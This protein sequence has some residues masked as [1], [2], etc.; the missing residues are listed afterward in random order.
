M[1]VYRLNLVIALALSCLAASPVPA[2]AGEIL[3]NTAG[4]DYNAPVTTLKE[5]RFRRV[6]KQSYDFSCG[7]AAVATLLT[8]HYNRPILEQTVLQAMFEV[9]DQEKIRKEGFSM[10][11]MKKYLESLGYRV[12]G[13]QVSLDKVG[14]VGIPGI[15]LIKTN[16]YLHFVVLK[17][18]RGGQ[19]LL[20]DSALGTKFMSREKFIEV[21]NGIFLAIITGTRQAKNEF[22]LDKDWEGQ[23]AA[24][25]GR[26]LSRE[27]L[28]TLTLLM[29]GRNNF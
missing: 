1:A 6:V 8:Y 10:L 15:V 26:A 27:S 16:G 23:V 28:S 14:Q 29:P 17:G 4:Y 24:P 5:L 9:G 13:Y 22:N 3:I 11:D 12:E 18:V 21:W 20:G 7:S 19:V 2:G 25:L